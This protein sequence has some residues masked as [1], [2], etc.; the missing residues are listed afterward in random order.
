[1][2]AMKTKPRLSRVMRLSMKVARAA[3]MKKRKPSHVRVMKK[4]TRVMKKLA[5][6]TTMEESSKDSQGQGG[7]K[8]KKSVK[9]AFPKASISKD[10]QGQGGMKVKKPMKKAPP[11]AYN[12]SAAKKERVR[13]L[14]QGETTA[15][16]SM[17][18]MKAKAVNGVPMKA[19]IKSSAIV[20]ENDVPDPSADDLSA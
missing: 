17:K 8:V 19:V 2:K 20:V 5:R 18:V 9:K 16:G 7:M 14:Q 12:T 10:S 3:P 13:K 6:V 15:T 4:M 11:K 1:M